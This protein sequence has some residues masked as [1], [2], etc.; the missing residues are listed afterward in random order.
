MHWLGFGL[1][2]QIPARSFSGGGVQLPVCSRDTGIYVG[3]CV[4]LLVIAVLH[5]PDRP[6][7]F[8]SVWGWI[9][10]ATMVGSMAVDGITENLGLRSTTNE[11]R[12][13]TGLLCG[14][15]IAMLLTPML[16]DSVWKTSQPQRVLDPP[17]RLVMW[18]LTV[19]VMYVAIWWGGPL[20]G[21][22]YPMLAA[23]AVIT[24]LTCVNLVMV[25]LAP[26]FER[27]ASRLLDLW[28]A[29]AV[30]LCLT[31]L[32]VGLSGV[33]KGVLIGAVSRLS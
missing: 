23:V 10:F 11:L 29:V 32:E 17:L 9:A 15:A 2:H 1:C 19:P 20:L 24:T 33:L 27:R 7:E 21:V 14:Y 3:C 30:A 25:C 5:R 26:W 6:R 8:P 4:S 31:F 22:L 18:L 28:P 13:I 12:L 16:N